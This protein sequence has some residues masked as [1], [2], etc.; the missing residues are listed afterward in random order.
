MPKPFKKK[1][2]KNLAQVAGAKKFIKN[3]E[4][5]SNSSQHSVDLDEDTHSESRSGLDESSEEFDD[6]PLDQPPSLNAYSQEKAETS[7]GLPVQSTSVQKIS[8]QASANRQRDLLSQQR[9]VAAPRSTTSSIRSGSSQ[10]RSTSAIEKGNTFSTIRYEKGDGPASA[11]L[12]D[13]LAA[14]SADSATP[15]RAAASP[16][17]VANANPAPT[18]LF[19]DDAP[20]FTGNKRSAESLE[21]D[22]FGNSPAPSQA[23]VQAGPPDPAR[24]VEEWKARH[25]GQAP[26]WMD[27]CNSHLSSA[28]GF[29]RRQLQEFRVT[30][31]EL[32]SFGRLMQGSLDTWLSV[33]TV[34]ELATAMDTTQRALFEAYEAEHGP[35][36][37]ELPDPLVP[38]SQPQLAQLAC[39]QPACA[40]PMA[41]T[42][43]QHTAPALTQ[44]AAPTPTHTL[45]L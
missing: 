23:S 39:A 9:M 28:A 12:E 7:P 26:T 19:P 42:P 11:S 24:M 25:F 6:D 10:D 34:D 3:T 16:S 21:E 8:W 41:P 4:R 44:P 37:V 45:A 29:F 1:T 30:L 31:Q 13:R 2:K 20:R 15:H 38:G 17:P 27:L 35:Y 5:V 33:Y 36:G 40:Q 18:V 22:Q 43:A 14:Q 32:T